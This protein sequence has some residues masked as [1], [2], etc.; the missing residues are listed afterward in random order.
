VSQPTP[1]AA[2]PA[3]QIQTEISNQVAEVSR[4][5][6]HQHHGSEQTTSKANVLWANAYDADLRSTWLASALNTQKD[7]THHIRTSH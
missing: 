4:H 3:N 7:D 2:N 6:Y 5:A 1:L